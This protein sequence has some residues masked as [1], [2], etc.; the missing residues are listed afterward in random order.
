M[1]RQVLSE[2]MWLL[3]LWGLLTS[4]ALLMLLVLQ[5]MAMPTDETSLI[6]TQEY[7]W[8]MSTIGWWLQ[9]MCFAIS[10]KMAWKAIYLLRGR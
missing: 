3:V 9:A 2:N 5:A 7:F 10:I 8:W 4:A 6:N 1:K